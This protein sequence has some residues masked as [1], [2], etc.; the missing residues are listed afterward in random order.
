MARKVTVLME[1]E[2]H[3]DDFNSEEFQAFLKDITDANKEGASG[4]EDEFCKSKF[5]KSSYVVK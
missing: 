1:M 3:D 4:F 5:V 2:V